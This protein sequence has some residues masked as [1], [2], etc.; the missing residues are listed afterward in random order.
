MIIIEYL[1]QD[2]DLCQQEHDPCDDIVKVFWEL[3]ELDCKFLGYYY[4]E[5][6]EIGYKLEDMTVN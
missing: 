6:P 3:V 4:E 2:G 1:D 5:H